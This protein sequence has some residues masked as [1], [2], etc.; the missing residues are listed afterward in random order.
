MR[1]SWRAPVLSGPARVTSYA[2]RITPGSG[3]RHGGRVTVP[4]GRLHTSF[5]HL[6]PGRSYHVTVRAVSAAGRSPHASVD[7]L[8]ARK[9]SAWVFAT[10]T[11]TAAVVRVWLRG[12]RVTTIAPSRTAWAVNTQGDVYVIDREAQTVSRTKARG[13]ST[14]VIASGLAELKDIQLDA[15]GQ[16]YVLAGT[17]VVRMSATGARRRVVAERASYSVFVRPDGTVLTTAG[18]ADT[19]PLQI[20]SYPPGGGAPTVRTLP[21][22]NG[23]AYYAYRRGLVADSAGNVF[24]H[25]V[26]EG[27]SDFEWWYRVAAG[28]TTRTRLYTRMANFAFALG[29]GG[30]SYLAQT[31]TYCDIMAI[32]DGVCTPDQRVYSILRYAADGTPTRIPVEPFVYDQW[33]LYAGSALAVDRA[34]RLFVAQASGPSAGLREYAPTGGAA[35]VLAAGAFTD[36]VRNN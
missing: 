13:R 26:S 7:Y 10:N 18:D 9:A 15:A 31:T 25:W 16:V 28:S 32:L 8:A 24:V 22:Q 14:I 12:S 33:G 34:G 23:G 17:R 2:V 11:T 36:V 30:R 20:L 4:A 35:K 19:T 1:V 6:S 29:A 5:G 21:G 3:L 27:G